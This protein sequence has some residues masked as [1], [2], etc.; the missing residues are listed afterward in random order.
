MKLYNLRLS[1]KNNISIL[2]VSIDSEILGKKEL[3]FSTDQKYENAI[4][5]TQYDAF[6]V[7]LLYPAM[8]YGE[9][10]HI[11]G[12]VSKKLLFNTNNY[13]I[14]LVKSFSPSCKT[15]KVTAENTINYN[16]GGSG[17]GTGFSGGVDSFCTIYDHYELEKD[18][19]Y[20]INSLLFLNVGA[21]GYKDDNK[22]REKF[23][24]RYNYLKKFPN[25]IGLDF[26]SVDSNLHL[27]HPWGH[28]K[29]HTLTSVSGILFLQN[30]YS[31]Y[32]YASAGLNYG[33]V[34]RSALNYR[35]IDIGAY[36]DPILLPLLSTESLEL[37]PDG[38]QYTRV[39]KTLRILN[40]MPVYKYLNVCVSGDDTHE[41]C[42]ICNKC[43]RTIMTL[44]SVGKLDEF[45]QLFDINKYRKL[46]EKKYICK[47]V[48]NQNKDPFA[49][50]N[51]NLAKANNVRL[52]NKLYC[53]IMVLS[54]LVRKTM[55][56]II[57]RIIPETAINKIKS[58]IRK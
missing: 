33:F 56:T 16:F 30:F 45:K 53:V 57:K 54:G 9:D 50:A 8:K 24:I 3:W 12:L 5:S 41:N 21:H 52:P 29:T 4:C 38:T 17:I 13:V 46:A 49:K 37:I 48:L 28:Q 55:I 26:I 19:E 42:S 47:Q 15:I 1:R 2:S 43:C 44:N 35:D 51:I 34:I 31:K 25:E 7:G 11:N 14:P 27:F 39:E 6:L 20:K 40:Y 32:Y 10:I 18:P 36:C 23:K 58:F 22:A